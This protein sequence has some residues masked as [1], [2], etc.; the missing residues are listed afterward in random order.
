MFP[1]VRVFEKEGN[2][3]KRC[4]IKTALTPVTHE[5][6][7]RFVGLAIWLLQTYFENML[8]PSVRP[9]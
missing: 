7:N 3:E 1:A 5:S 6:P 2:L 8:L 4:S 9:I